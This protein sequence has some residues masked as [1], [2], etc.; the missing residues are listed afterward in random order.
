MR[1]LIRTRRSSQ[2]VGCCRWRPQAPRQQWAAVI[3]RATVPS[4][5]QD[6]VADRLRTVYE[7]MLS[8]IIRALRRSL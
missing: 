7:A 4:L 8:S 6:A 1:Q 2:R 3:V 5:S